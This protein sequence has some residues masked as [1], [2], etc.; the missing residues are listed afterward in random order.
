LRI[1]EEA[2]HRGHQA[3]LWLY[4]EDA[5]ITEAGVMNVFFLLKNNEGG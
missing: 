5:K 3:V 1:Q 2:K 4:G